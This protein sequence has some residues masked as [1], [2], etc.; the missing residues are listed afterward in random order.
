ML[1]DRVITKVGSTEN[2]QIDVRVIAATNRDLQEMVENKT[3]RRDLYYRLNV[4]PIEIP[5]LSERYEDV[6]IM[7]QQC[8]N[9]YNRKYGMEKRIDPS[10]LRYLLDYKWPG[11]VRELENI[12]EYLV[13]TTSRDII[14][15]EDLPKEVYDSSGK[16]GESMSFDQ[17]IS[18]KDAVEM[19][20]KKML[21][22]AMLDS[23]NT[24]DMAKKLGVDRSTVTRKLQKYDMKAKF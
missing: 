5:P 21:R 24:E 16:M 8:L 7:V 14:E 1:Q 12:I 6:K 9:K 23:K 4:V 2:I 13:V 15:K 18:L 22:E 3:F 19:V 10:A 20:E 17:G 11:N